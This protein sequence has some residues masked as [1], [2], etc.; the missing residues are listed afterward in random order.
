MFK[1]FTISLLLIAIVL[2]PAQSAKYTP[3]SGVI[4]FQ[5]KNA[6][7]TVNGSI[8]GIKAQIV[9]DQEDLSASKIFASVALSTISTGIK[10]R[11]RHLQE[12][13]YFDSKNHPAIKM[14][15]I[16]VKKSSQGFTGIFD[17]TMKGIQKQIS[18]P[19]T[20]SEEGGNY[21]FNG[22]LSLNR[23]DFKVGGSSMILSDNVSVQVKITAKR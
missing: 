3:M 8:S 21:I 13:E 5:I 23:R 17:L 22:T 4:T 10:K 2:I 12:E 16:S 7:M 6:G 20:I 11:D 14:N 9:L 15:L 18:M 19:F 1:T